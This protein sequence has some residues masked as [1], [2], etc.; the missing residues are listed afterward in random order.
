MSKVYE[1]TVRYLID[2]EYDNADMDEVGDLFVDELE[3]PIVFDITK[4]EEDY[5]EGAEGEVGE[6][7][8]QCK[9]DRW[10]GYDIREIDDKRNDAPE[11]EG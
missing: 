2:T 8:A 9:A 5:E 6:E 3:D 11:E 10:G 4:D 7:T 1:V